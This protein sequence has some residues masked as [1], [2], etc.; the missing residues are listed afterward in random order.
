MIRYLCLFLSD[1]LPSSFIHV[2]A[3][4][5][6]SLFLWVSSIPL[7][8]SSS[9]F[10]YPSRHIYVFSIRQE[11]K[12]LIKQELAGVQNVCIVTTGDLET[13]RLQLPDASKYCLRTVGDVL[14]S[15]TIQKMQIL[16]KAEMYLKPHSQQPSSFILNT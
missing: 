9:S 16:S 7:C 15:D 12:V 1:L 3:N 10:I 6:I 14:E 13:T 4:G 2:A 5:K 11:L 8:I